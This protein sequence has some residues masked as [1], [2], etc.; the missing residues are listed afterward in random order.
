MKPKHNRIFCIGCHHGKMWFESQAKADNFL[1]FNKESIAAGSSKV[2]TRSYYCSFCCGWHVTSI[3]DDA[4][5]K[6]REE[7]DEKLW[8]TIRRRNAGLSKLEG[9]DGNKDIRI[10]KKK[11]LPNTEEGW[12]LHILLNDIDRICLDGISAMLVTDYSRAGEL[13]GKAQMGYE[14][15]VA[16][17]E[18]YGIYCKKIDLR[19]VKIEKYVSRLSTLESLV[20]SPEGRREVLASLLVSGKD[21][22]FI[23]MIRNLDNVEMIESLFSEASVALAD[24][25]SERVRSVCVKIEHIVSEELKGFG[26]RHRKIYTDRLSEILYRNNDQHVETS[27][28]Q[29]EKETAIRVIDLLQ[30]SYSALEKGDIGTADAKLREAVYLIP[31]R[32]N[33]SIDIL[34]RQSE[35]LYDLIHKATADVRPVKTKIKVLYLHGFTSSGSCMV[36]KSL[37]IHTGSIA[38]VTSPDLPL[39]P[40]EAMDMLVNLCDA[41]RF[42]I[43]V[44]ASCGGFYAQQLVRLTGIP[45][46]LINPYFRMTEFLEARVGRHSYKSVRADG[47]NMF[48]IT[49]ELIGEFRTMERDQFRM[50]DEFNRIRVWGLFGKADALADF[51]SEFQQYYPTVIDFEGGHTMTPMNVKQTLVPAIRR[52][53]AEVKPARKRYFRHFKGNEYRL[54]NIA[55]D[56]ETGERMAVY[57]DCHGEHVLW[58]RPEKM[59]FERIQRDGL[60]FPRFAEISGPGGKRE[61]NGI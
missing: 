37:K 45:A 8:E 50:Y 10:P 39:H 29:S 14:E 16:R 7:R 28:T 35:K 2:P 21:N 5:A 47:N 57:R 32:A 56:S 41:H 22:D 17:S 20:G 60:E 11:K 53:A 3:D 42:D 4:V 61:I 1:K 46:I 25:D 59:F 26:P 12:H 58:I 13:F 6:E 15:V 52:M 31:E 40:Y 18:A 24:Q 30:E 9:D 23:D 55:R 19:G 38:V 48:E 44:G 54:C 34:I 27:L 36:A 51:R 43:I 49:P 33:K